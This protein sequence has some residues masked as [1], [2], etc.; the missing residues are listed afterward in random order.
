[1][2]GGGGGGIP[3][4]KIFVYVQYLY[5]NTFL[6][7]CLLAGK[8]LLCAITFFLYY[9]WEICVGE[10]LSVYGREGG[11]G[12]GIFLGSLTFT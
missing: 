4:R 12:G 1:M 6:C 7:Q 10:N 2:R 3:P 8:S 11:G 9:T 5:S